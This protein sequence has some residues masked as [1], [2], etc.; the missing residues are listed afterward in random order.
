M[1]SLPPLTR[2]IG[3]AERALRALL[4]EVLE[5]AGLS[6]PEWVALTSL[7]AG[8]MSR[9]E[10]IRRLVAGRVAEAPVAGAALDDLSARGLIAPVGEG[11]RAGALARTPAGE[12]VHRPLGQAVSALTVA[13]YG[14]LPPDDLDVAHRTLTEIA[15]R[16]GARLGA[17]PR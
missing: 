6:F 11:Q 13:L 12:A 1:S 9:G 8:P 2:S 14:D 7:G 17:D 15:R 3:Q 10:L 5:P 16:A 4:G